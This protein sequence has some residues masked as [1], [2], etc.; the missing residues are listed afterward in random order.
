MET[1]G[2]MDTSVEKNIIL[3]YTENFLSNYQICKKYGINRIYVQRVLKRNGVIL[4]KRRSDI[5][6]NHNFFREYNSYSCYWAGFILA[7]G[8]IRE[9]KRNT[10]CI[11]LSIRDIEH[12]EKFKNLI[13][14]EGEIEKND[15]FCRIS[16]SSKK[17]IHDLSEKFS[18]R[19]RKTY[20]AYIEE[21]IPYEFLS[22]FI[23]GYLDGDGTLC[24]TSCETLG[25]IGTKKTLESIR[26]FI[27][28]SGIRLRTKER[29]EITE[30]K[31]SNIYNLSYY[32][33]SAIKTCEIL[34]KESEEI[35][36]L[37]RKFNIFETWKMK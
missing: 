36:R 7:D 19:S 28:Q 22:H 17:I 3:D 24:K 33:K 14:F 9:D 5:K 21:K 6:V 13:E 27:F 1:I 23:R 11:K 8:Y 15:I 31:S 37:T 2:S 25:F 12:L 16:I 4:E 20:I 10:L 35:I 34:Y 29:P 30:N 26:E 18:I 32:G